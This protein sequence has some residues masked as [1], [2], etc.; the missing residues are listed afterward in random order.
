LLA[1]LP[2]SALNA[3]VGFAGESYRSS[4]SLE[5]HELVGS[6]R[7]KNGSYSHIP[8][9]DRRSRVGQ[10]QPEFSLLFGNGVGQKRRISVL[11]EVWRTQDDEDEN[12]QIVV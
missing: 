3:D 10:Y 6:R 8:V 9:S 4:A 12:W 1:Y 11:V 2:A 7:R 5:R